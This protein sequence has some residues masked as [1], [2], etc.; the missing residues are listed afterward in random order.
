MKKIYRLYL[1]LRKKHQEPQE[2]WRKWCKKQKTKKDKEEIVLGAILTQRTNWRNVEMV[3]K[4]LKEAKSLS[5]EKIYQLGK[6]RMDLLERLVRP[7]GFYRQKAQRL[8]QLCQFMVKTHG[9]L[10]RFFSQ[11]L[12][13]CREQL[14][15]I[16]GIGP[17]TADSILLYAAGKP[18]FV[19][20]EYTR[21]LVKKH[22]L[23]PKF[24]YDYLQQLFQQNLPKNVKLYQDFHAMIVL[25]GKEG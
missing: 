7:S 9:S 23:A 14:L 3:F 4:N 25:E 5:I 24:S 6:K 22:R 21:R 18:I 20:D 1:Q 10:A 11:D 16:Y 15:E 19:I 8:F 17:E 13:T 2:F 12:T